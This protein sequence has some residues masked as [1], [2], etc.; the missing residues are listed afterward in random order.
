MI[1]A[2]L[3]I[4]T[5]ESLS[6]RR[7][8]KSLEPSPDLPVDITPRD[9][10]FLKELNEFVEFPISIWNMLCDNGTMIINEYFRLWADDPL[11][12]IRSKQAI[13]ID[14]SVQSKC[15]LRD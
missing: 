3:E 4:T 5:D 1:A 8:I 6:T 15:F 13:T 11:S 2:M 10:I 12:L 7:A 14:T 9:L